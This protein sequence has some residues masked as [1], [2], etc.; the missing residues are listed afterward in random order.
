MRT[1]RARAF[2]AI[3]IAALLC[4]PVLP[5]LAQSSA[6]IPL[7]LLSQTP[8]T[9]LQDPEL[10]IGFLATNASE[11]PMRHLSV[12][13]SLGPSFSSR[14]DYEAAITTGPT[15]IVS[16]QETRF[17]G[18]LDAGAS[19]TFALT[20]DMSEMPGVDQEDSRVY[21]VR[22]ELR[23]EGEAIARLHSNAIHLVRLPEQ[24][25]RLS[26]WLELP[27]PV[28]FAPD[29]RLVD[30]TF[31]A[32]LA[33][34][35]ALAA[36]VAAARAV[37]AAT[38]A[39][40]DVVVQPS[41]VEQA[42]RMARGY[43]RADGTVVEPGTGPAADASAFLTQLRALAAEPSVQ[44]IAQPLDAPSVPSML[45]SGLT[46]DLD[47]QEDR[48]AAVI[49]QGMGV[50][51]ASVIA[52]PPGGLL[53]TLAIGHYAAQARTV[54]LAEA[55]AV[56]RPP[57][58]NAFAP[59]PTA[60]V[61]GSGGTSV[62][63]VMPDPGTQ[64]LLQRGDLVADPIRASQAVLGELAVIWKEE[65][66]PEPP[67]V[68]GI[69]LALPSTLPTTMW[70]ALLGRLAEA[71]FLEPMH[72]AELVAEVHPPG[73]GATLRSPSTV[74]FSQAYA[75]RIEELHADV[76]AYGSMLVEP[77]D[78][79]SSMHRSLLQAEGREFLGDEAAGTAWLDPVAATTEAAFASTT[80]QVR[81]AF[82]FTGREG[83]IPL[84][85]GDPGEVR[86]RVIVQLQSSQFEFPDGAEQEVI[87]ERPNQ[88]VEFTV[89]AK[90]SGQNPI[91]VTVR[92]P[93]GRAISQQ[94]IVVRTSAVNAIAV[95]ITIGAAIG[96]LLM[97]ARRWFRRTRR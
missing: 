36:P 24:P 29:G 17:G 76:D 57:Q 81:Q 32:A 65:P 14:Y 10:R 22:V 8:W 47:R 33:P 34:G 27:A 4:S 48:G 80:P 7:T 19:R 3:A 77:G 66:I 87:L 20:V 16:S 25:L 28:A 51:P 94:T 59:P 84:R 73:S 35:G 93:G 68:R 92:T 64:A 69:A 96:L 31:E 55:D 18:P 78:V 50:E 40:V 83:T 1:R 49:R 67:D 12:A 38:G 11:D 39:D 21:P 13:V 56:D 54:V 37:S 26:W 5:A 53:D 72:P 88:L 71:P 52:H 60:V 74:A 79:A 61:E 42:E 6:I 75:E 97:Y 43:A 86:L 91:A 85:M 45:L 46:I 90:A 23:S 63:L 82:T 41:L 9:T 30:A 15:S 44:T 2:L 95:L 89:V 70:P 58:V 62:T